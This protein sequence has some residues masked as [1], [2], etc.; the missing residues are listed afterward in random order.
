[1]DAQLTKIDNFQ[2]MEEMLAYADIL[3]KSK[4][5]PHSTKEA[6]VTI[7]QYGR[8]LGIGFS[9]AQQNIHNIQGKPTISTKLE[10]ALAKRHGVEWVI[11]KDFEPVTNEK[12]ELID[13]VTTLIF[14][15]ESKLRKGVIINQKISF[16]WQ[17]AVKAGWSQ[18]DNWKKYPKNMMMA[19]C[20]TKGID[21]VAPECKM[22]FYNAVE[23]ADSMDKVAA[24]DSG[25]Y[26]I[27]A[28]GNKIKIEE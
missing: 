19:R 28:N 1:M 6:V 27:D 8:D 15:T 2:T 25:V 18:K 12:G 3:V 9:I 14:Y 10:R 24:D 13:Y 16:Y 26:I 11:E 21:M 7:A 17:D 5:V 22:G 4:L 20:F 23:I